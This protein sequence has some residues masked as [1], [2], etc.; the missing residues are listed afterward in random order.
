MPRRPPRERPVSGRGEETGDGRSGPGAPVPAL[1]SASRLHWPLGRRGA[2]GRAGRG[3]EGGRP[4]DG[5][6]RC[7]GQY[8]GGGGGGG[9]GTRRPRARGARGSGA[10]WAGGEPTPTPAWDLT[11]APPRDSPEPARLRD[12]SGRGCR[13]CLP[14]GRPPDTANGSPSPR[15]HGEHQQNVRLAPAGF[16]KDVCQH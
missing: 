3:A 13:P 14:P 15:R 4:L 9:G 11:A 10:I 12:F 2:R 6:G 16:T 7:G 5:A 1:L 8:P